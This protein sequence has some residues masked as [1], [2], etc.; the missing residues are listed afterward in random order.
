M[1]KQRAEFWELVRD[2][3]TLNLIFIDESGLNLALTRSHARSLKGQRVH[4]SRP[5]KRGDNVSLIGALGLKGV[6]AATTV[7][8]SVNGLTFE[9]FIGGKL[10]PKLWPGAWVVMDNCSI[11][12]RAEIEALITEAGA[13]VLF[14]PPYS[15]EF[16]P[17]EH[18]WSK[19][20]AILRQLEAR[21]YPDLAAAVAEAFRHISLQD[22]ENWFLHCCYPVHH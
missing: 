4:G 21:T 11:H 18:L 5:A 14:L 2:I 7:L 17:I 16:S 19:L 13:R 8:G 9:A 12:H 15:P 22:I 3:L 1:Q 20:K 6:I 10:V